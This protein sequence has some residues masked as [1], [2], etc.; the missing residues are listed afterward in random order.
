MVDASFWGLGATCARVPV[1]EVRQAGRL[2][3][4]W[5][6]RGKGRLDAREAARQSG[7]LGQIPGEEHRLSDYLDGRLLYYTGSLS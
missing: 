4:R 6:F 1:S 3:E 5:F 7:L 2:R